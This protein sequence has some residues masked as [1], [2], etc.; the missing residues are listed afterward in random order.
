[1]K[2][3][4]GLI[5]NNF[6]FYRY[7]LLTGIDKL[8]AILTIIIVISLFKDKLLFNEL[9]YIFAI[10]AIV[11]IFLELGLSSYVFYGFKVT[12][13]KTLFLDQFKTTYQ[14]L[15]FYAMILTFVSLIFG[16]FKSFFFYYVLVKAFSIIFLNILKSYVRITDTPEKIF[17]YSIPTNLI[18]IIILSVFYFF[19]IKINLFYFLLP[20]LILLIFLFFKKINLRFNVKPVIQQSLIFAWPI[21][22]NSILYIILN[23]YIKIYAYNFFDSEEMY[24]ISII[25]RF[26]QVTFIIQVATVAFFSKKLYLQKDNHI[27]WKGLFLYF[28]VL[29]FSVF[30]SILVTY[31]YIR[32]FTDTL[33][34]FNLLELNYVLL[35]I[36]PALFCFNAFIELYFGR[37][38]QNSKMLMSSFSGFL[39]FIILF[40][41]LN[42]GDDLL[43]LNIATFSAII[44]TLLIRLQFLF[45][46]QK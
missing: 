8:L 10:S 3:L 4:V 44:T 22:F 23:N 35:F 46:W 31:L 15:G 39:I 29:L 24:R 9:E 2:Y 11:A 30:L 17:W 1:M 7:I 36:Y 20:N 18:S 21:I 34:V 32:F 26:S 38:N 45:K 6:K 13:D 19:N 5:S 28:F 16:F 43:K 41:L 37:K 12:K 27:N 25:Q 40:T 33:F 14:V 42:F